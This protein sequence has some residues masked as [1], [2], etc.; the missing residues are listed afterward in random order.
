MQ[1]D[2]R[3]CMN[4]R[5]TDTTPN[6][7]KRNNLFFFSLRSDSFSASKKSFRC[8]RHVHHFL[9]GHPCFFFSCAAPSYSLSCCFF[10]VLMQS[11]RTRCDMSE[12]TRELYRVCCLAAPPHVSHSTDTHIPLLPVFCFST[13]LKSERSL[14]WFL[15]LFCIGV[16][17]LF[18]S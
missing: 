14:V 17:S 12:R 2:R 13:F 11:G 6:N 10:C 4:G 3:T 16:L 18:W 1:S 5:S 15:F 7:K 9:S 8:G